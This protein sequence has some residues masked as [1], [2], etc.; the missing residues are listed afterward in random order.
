MLDSQDTLVIG[1]ALITSLVGAVLVIIGFVFRFGR[2]FGTFVSAAEKHDDFLELRRLD[3]IFG[4]FTASGIVLLVMCVF[5]ILGILRRNSIMLKLYAA[6]IAL[7]VLVQLVTGLLAFTYS[8]EVNRLVTNDVL[9]KS[10][11]GTVI[12]YSSP[13][14]VADND[15]TK[16]WKITQENLKCC[17]MDSAGDWNITM[18]PPLSDFKAF[19]DAINCHQPNYSKGCVK[20]I[21]SRVSG[22]ATY[23]AVAA[24]A[25]LLVE[26]IASFMAGWRAFTINEK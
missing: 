24:M 22:D 20:Q 1:S 12:V 13:G 14:N 9:Q 15:D 2:G 5:A 8:D 6:A 7:M 18:P 4:L 19:M 10:L 21:R 17:G 26:I 11:N 25:V 23:I 3:M 16:F